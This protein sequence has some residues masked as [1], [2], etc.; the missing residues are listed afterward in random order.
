M[1]LDGQRTQAPW[2]RLSELIFKPSNLTIMRK[3][4]KESRQQRQGNLYKQE[5]NFSS[6]AIQKMGTFPHTQF[7]T[8]LIQAL[9]WYSKSPSGG[10]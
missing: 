3:Q 6:Y 10:I 4:K 9:D 7:H 5:G 1:Y 2:R 8:T